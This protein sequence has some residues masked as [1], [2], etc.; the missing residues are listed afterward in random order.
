MRD[1]LT[2]VQAKI[3]YSKI[4][5]DELVKRALDP[6]ENIGAFAPCSTDFLLHELGTRLARD[7]DRKNFDEWNQAINKATALEIAVASCKAIEKV[8]VFIIFI[9]SLTLFSGSVLRY[10]Y[11]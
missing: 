2:T 4:P 1:K 11:H 8:Y 6:L 5:Y 7:Y 10:F 9:L 3:D